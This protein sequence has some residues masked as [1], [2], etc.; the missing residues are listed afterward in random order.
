MLPPVTK[1]A[2]FSQL[3]GMGPPQIGFVFDPFDAAWEQ[4]FEEL[5]LV[6]KD[7]GGKAHVPQGDSERPELGRWCFTQARDD[8]PPHDS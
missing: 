6:A 3:S 4:S 2:R 1:H 7:D 8:P 5:R